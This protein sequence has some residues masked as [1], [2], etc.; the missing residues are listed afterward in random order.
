MS[1]PE[2]EEATRH[3]F[4]AILFRAAREHDRGVA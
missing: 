3:V 4:V 2:T 1:R